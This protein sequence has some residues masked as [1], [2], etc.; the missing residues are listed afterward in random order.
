MVGEGKLRQHTL[1][2]VIH[3]KIGLRRQDDDQRCHRAHDDRVNEHRK[4]LYH[5]LLGRM[6]DIGGRRHIRR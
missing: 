5:A 3:A 4:G 2:L 6:L 1:Y